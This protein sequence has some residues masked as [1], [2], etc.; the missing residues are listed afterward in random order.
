MLT[1]PGQGRPAAA[2]VSWLE[3]GPGLSKIEHSEFQPIHSDRIA[4][5]ITLKTVVAGRALLS[6]ERPKGDDIESEPEI[7]DLND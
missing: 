5:R 7:M 3:A 6:F 1:H 4:R 2:L